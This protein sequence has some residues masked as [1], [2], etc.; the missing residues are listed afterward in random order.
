MLLL[1]ILGRLIDIGEEIIQ[2]PIHPDIDINGYMDWLH[3]DR[4]HFHLAAGLH[5]VLG[6]AQAGK[7]K[8]QGCCTEYFFHKFLLVLYGHLP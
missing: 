1:Y 5:L 7:E 6:A 2:G 4:R 8:Q 3:L